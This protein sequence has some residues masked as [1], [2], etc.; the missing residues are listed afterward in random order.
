MTEIQWLVDIMLNHKLPGPVKDKF[1]ARIGEVESQLSILGSSNGRTSS[2]G[3]ENVGSI[4]TPR[5]TAQAP[6]TQRILDEMKLETPVITPRPIVS[7][8][9]P[10]AIDKETGRAMVATGKGTFGPRKF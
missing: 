8:P 10:D 6:S 3:L 9:K 5:S 7:A 4:P 1:I 2:F